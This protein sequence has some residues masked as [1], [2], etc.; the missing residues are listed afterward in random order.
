MITQTPSG[1]VTAGEGVG[2][3]L[4]CLLQGAQQGDNI[5]YVWTK[6]GNNLPTGVQN[7]G[8]THS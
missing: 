5:Q 6:D 1:T 3:S 4:E 8:G 2:V 7:N